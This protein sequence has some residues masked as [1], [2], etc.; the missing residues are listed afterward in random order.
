MREV[1]IRNSIDRPVR[2]IY[3]RFA[4]IVAAYTVEGPEGVKAIGVDS[5]D[6]RLR[7]YSASRFIVGE[8]GLVLVP[9]WK[10]ITDGIGKDTAAVRKRLEALKEL[11]D[12]GEVS[13]HICDEL[14]NE[15][16]SKLKALEDNHAQVSQYLRER[17]SE[18][19]QEI[20]T[21][22]RFTLEVK[23]QHRSGEM[24]DEA[25]KRVAANC[26]YL[27]TKNL[28]EKGEIDRVLAAAV[29]QPA[30]RAPLPDSQAPVP[31]E[32]A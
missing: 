1:E 3:G 18:L 17:L 11:R 21:L 25:Y 15:Y 19:D 5:G 32:T 6:G 24:D 26:G 7:Q 22:E 9:E 12:E 13:P 27:T 31:T 20:A 30:E 2:D 29:D 10:L 28:Q 14:S 16:A 8:A 23:I 4:G